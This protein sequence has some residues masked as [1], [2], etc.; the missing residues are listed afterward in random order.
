MFF[1]DNYVSNNNGTCICTIPCKTV[2]YE[3]SLSF[4]Q[5]STLNID[6]LV[7]QGEG[8]RDTVF[9]Q[10]KN[11]REVLNRVKSEIYKEDNALMDNL[12]QSSSDMIIDLNN[13]IQQTSSYETFS[14][15]YDVINLYAIEQLFTEFA[16]FVSDNYASIEEH[17]KQYESIEYLSDK[18]F[19]KEN[20]IE[21]MI[22]CPEKTGECE[23]LIE[24]C[25]RALSIINA[26]NT[27]D[28]E[29]GMNATELFTKKDINVFPL[30]R[31]KCSDIVTWYDDEGG[32]ELND[33]LIEHYVEMIRLMEIAMNVSESD[34]SGQDE[35]AG[36]PP[37]PPG[38]TIKPG[39]NVEYFN[40]DD[41]T[42][43]EERWESLNNNTKLQLFHHYNSNE[44]Y[45]SGSS[46]RDEMRCEAPINSLFQCE[47]FHTLIS[48]DANEVKHD[49]VKQAEIAQAKLNECAVKYAE[50]GEISVNLNVSIYENLKPMVEEVLKFRS[51]KVTKESLSEQ[52]NSIT[53]LNYM[54]TFLKDLTT[55]KTAMLKMVSCIVDIEIQ[56]GQ[57]LEKISEQNYEIFTNS[58]YNQSRYGFELTRV[59]TTE[60]TQI[61]ERF[62]SNFEEEFNALGKAHYEKTRSSFKFMMDTV[63]N[64]GEELIQLMNWLAQSL[65]SYTTTI[66][67]NDAFY[68]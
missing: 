50:L 32:K 39:N 26:L 40:E 58:N 17:S 19:W 12:T 59:N 35:P 44:D 43:L 5:L 4:A 30:K 27:T 7:L 18:D 56:F 52:F 16:E 51:N 6:R 15:E 66:K 41:V 3:P 31:S 38:D 33:Q 37:A 23:E 20:I 28:I 65:S 2:K 34:E 8:K 21:K 49:I 55:F 45:G 47:C 53:A 11:A 22:N 9:K 25:E 68:R 60:Y 62:P 29:Y 36:P 54:D 13:L 67:M 1:S 48:E 46:E 61:I 24:R 63:S 14:M 64:Q 42:V 10:F 57:V